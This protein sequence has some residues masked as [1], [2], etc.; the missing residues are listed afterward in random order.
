[1]YTKQTLNHEYKATVYVRVADTMRYITFITYSYARRIYTRY[2]TINN[3][4]MLLPFHIHR[5]IMI[6]YTIKYNDIIIIIII[7]ID[8]LWM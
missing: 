7:F 8:N 3:N 5:C 4:I 2:D 1:M 6:I